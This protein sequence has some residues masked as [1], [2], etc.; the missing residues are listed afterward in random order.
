[1]VKA[2]QEQFDDL[3][4]IEQRIARLEESV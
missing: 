3:D 4:L 2:V 1:V